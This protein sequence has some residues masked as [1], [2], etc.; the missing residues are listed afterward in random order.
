MPGGGWVPARC[1]NPF[2]CGRILL[3]KTITTTMAILLLPIEIALLLALG[4]HYYSYSCSLL[5]H[6]TPLLLLLLPY[7][8]LLLLVGLLLLLPPSCGTPTLS[9]QARFTVSETGRQQI[10]KTAQ[11]LLLLL[12]PMP[13][14]WRRKARC[15]GVAPSSEAQGPLWGRSAIFGGARPAVGA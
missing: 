5:P 7:D 14:P 6:T 12:L 9:A 11:Q 8:Y 13:R 10:P 2:A 4:T 15:N 1:V 3:T